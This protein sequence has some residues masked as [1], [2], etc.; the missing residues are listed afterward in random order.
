M[1]YVEEI[2]EYNRGFVA[3]KGYEAYITTKY[4]K[5]KI[6]VISC[7][8]TRLSELLLPA[9]NLK[10]GDAKIIKV[11]GAV[12]ENPFDSVMRSIIIAIYE[13]GVNSIFV[14]GHHDC[15]MQGMKPDAIT[16][17]MRD[18]SIALEKIE[19][20]YGS[21]ID[22]NAWLNGFHLA[23]DSVTDTVSFIKQH[24]MVPADIEIHGFVIDP[25]TGKLD[26]I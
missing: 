16:E 7:M 18:K 21:K 15:G 13:L 1:P 26:K 14:V 22:I 2:L 8:D 6:A 10:N 25:V 23:E 17:K 4:P 5:K 11:A 20:K 3:S 12:V 24:P 19:M 9:L